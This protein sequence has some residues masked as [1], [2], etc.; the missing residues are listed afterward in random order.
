MT[1]NILAGVLFFF[2]FAMSAIVGIGCMGRIAGQE[3]F[4]DKSPPVG[5]EA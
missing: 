3:V 4:T 5:R 2:F 1:P